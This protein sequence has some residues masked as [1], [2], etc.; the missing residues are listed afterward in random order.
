MAIGQWVN[1]LARP[2]DPD[3]AAAERSQPQARSRSGAGSTISTCDPIPIGQAHVDLDLAPDPDRATA[4]PPG[5]PELTGSGARVYLT[6]MRIISFEFHD[7][8]SDWHLEETK[9]DQFNLL[10]GL[11]GAEIG[12]AS[13]RER[14]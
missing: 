5:G 3:R 11:S 1:D 10:V 4:P 9:F 6:A 7:K 2:R 13:C 8:K 14:V 12:R